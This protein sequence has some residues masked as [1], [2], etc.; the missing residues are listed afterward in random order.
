MSSQSFEEVLLE[1]I[2]ILDGAMGTMIQAHS[3]E[4]ADFRG[5]R[6]GQHSQDLAGDNELLTL[7]SPDLIRGIHEDFLEAGADIIETNTF[8]S[9]AMR[10]N[11][12]RSMG[13]SLL[14][15]VMGMLLLS[16]LRL[17]QVCRKRIIMLIAAPTSKMTGVS[18]QD[19]IVCTENM[20]RSIREVSHTISSEK[21]TDRSRL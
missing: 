14:S 9:N 8:G 18:I 12:V 6:F 15:M 17:F 2:L 1:R 7:T 19:I 10:R 20:G 16:R 21:Y 13:K 5:E 11:W 4:E 3:L